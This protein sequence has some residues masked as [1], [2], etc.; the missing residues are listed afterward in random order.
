VNRRE[1]MQTSVK[2]G[3]TASLLPP[4]TATT[5]RSRPKTSDLP[6]NIL[7]IMADQVTPFMIGPY[8]QKA[9]HTPHLDL[10]ARSGTVFDAAY[11][12]SPL[13]VPSRMSLWTGRLPHKIQA[14]DN[15]SE[16]AAHIPT[17]LH[18]LRRANYRTVASGKCHFIGPD[19]AHGFNERLTPDIFHSDFGPLPDWTLGPVLNK[20]TD[21][22][23]MLRMLGPHKW[24]KQMGFDQMTFDRTL[25]RL[26]EYAMGK[27]RDQPLFLYVSFTQP[28][29][30]YTTTKHYLDLYKDAE[31][32]LPKAHGNILELSPTYKWLVTQHGINLVNLSPGKIREARRNYLGMVSW[33][34]D[35]IGKLLAELRRL[36]LDKSFAVFFTSDHGAM[37]GEHGQWSKRYMLEWSSRVPLIVSAPGRLPAGRRIAAPVSLIDVLPT[38]ADLAGAKI[39]TELDGR[40]LLP[41]LKET[42][43]GDGRVVIAEY[44]GE[45]VI[46]PVRMVRWEQY[47]YIIVN[48]YPPQLYDLQADP[49]ENAN[50][51]GQAK[52]SQVESRLRGFALRGWDGPALQRAVL[53]NQQS[54]RVVRSMKDYGGIPQWEYEP[55]ETGT[56]DPDSD[57]IPFTRREY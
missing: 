15:A 26:R 19:Q 45:G 21:V 46:E 4:Q 17:T 3:V 31:I 36:D 32:P 40:S 18:Y 41:L 28:H 1:F 20:G 51:A 25:A 16:F 47:K 49:N 6:P 43:T 24:T 50:V 57:F 22:Q 33:V 48:D 52:Y 54:R 7:F 8:G 23:T 27:H 42:E 13:C 56:Y 35:R 29:D 44:L 38:L 39:E 30:P 2:G 10:L 55:I 37:L 9:A 34:D 5:A 11:C 14:Y 53:Q 12:G